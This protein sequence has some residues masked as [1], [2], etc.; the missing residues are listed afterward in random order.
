L[1][2]AKGAAVFSQPRLTVLGKKWRWYN[3]N[4][5]SNGVREMFLKQSLILIH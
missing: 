2:T 4:K 1:Y 5:G 3:K